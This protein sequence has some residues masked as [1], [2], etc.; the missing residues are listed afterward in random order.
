M[1][2]VAGRMALT[3]GRIE[4]WRQNGGGLGSRMPEA[5]WRE[6]V[7]LARVEGLYA[8]SRALG[9]DYT[10]LKHRLEKSP[11]DKLGEA[12]FVEVEMAPPVGGKAVV[13]FVGSHGRRM[14]IEMTGALDV[15]GLMQAFWRS[16]G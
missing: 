4:H 3:R 1:E 8:T 10:R 14:R 2:Q 12:G 5:L 9:I 6:A 15:A 16:E 7:G 13:E 11:A